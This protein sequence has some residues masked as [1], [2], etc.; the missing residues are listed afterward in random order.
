MEKKMWKYYILIKKESIW[1]LPRKRERQKIKTVSDT[2]VMWGW[3]N[4]AY[5]QVV[6]WHYYWWQKKKNTRTNRSGSNSNTMRHNKNI[7][8]V[9]QI[10]KALKWRLCVILCWGKKKCNEKYSER[11]HK[12]A[13]L[14]RNVFKRYYST[15]PDND[16]SKTRVML[17]VT[18]T[19]SPAGMLITIVV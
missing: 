12:A 9:L 14:N 5:I 6:S 4:A 10:F 11:G 13:N 19:N 3:K 2:P 1:V 17:S 8:C 18:E 15:Y 7:R 16:S